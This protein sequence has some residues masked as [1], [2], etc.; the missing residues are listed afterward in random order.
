MAAGPVK[1]K[2]THNTPLRR[3]SRN[4]PKRQTVPRRLHHQV[5]E[6]R[7]SSLL[8]DPHRDR[9]AH[10]AAVAAVDVA[11]IL[12][13]GHDRSRARENEV[14]ARSVRSGLETRNAAIAPAS[15]Q[16]GGPQVSVATGSN[17]HRERMPRGVSA[18][19]N[20]VADRRRF[21]WRRKWCSRNRFHFRFRRDRWRG[22]SSRKSVMAII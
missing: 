11:R 15:K 16:M 12:A 14:V 17:D 18:A 21:Q 6:S 1:V 5:R 20:R 8:Q 9:V 3:T 22:E 10:K 2:S 4:R 7:E 19:V 13:S